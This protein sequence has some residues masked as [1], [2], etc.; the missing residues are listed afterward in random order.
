[1]L[2]TCPY[3]CPKRTSTCLQPVV[4]SPFLLPISPDMS[5]WE[6]N[7]GGGRRSLV[8]HLTSDIPATFS[9]QLCVPDELGCA[10][11]G[12]I[13]SVTAV[14]RLECLPDRLFGVYGEQTHD[15]SRLFIRRLKERTR[16]SP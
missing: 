3:L 1:M 6:V 4:I 5:T 16:V 2:K 14:R 10:P 12:E 8:L 13:H 7:V 15:A 11:Q 9:A